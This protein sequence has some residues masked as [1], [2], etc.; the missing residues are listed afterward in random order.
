MVSRWKVWGA[1]VALWVWGASAVGAQAAATTVSIQVPPAQRLEGATTVA[2]RAGEL[3]RNVVV[4]KSNLP[5]TLVAHVVE[6]SGEV[7]W[8][9][10]G[11][12]WQPIG[13]RSPV[14]S[15]RPGVHAVDYQLRVVAGPAGG[16]LA[17]VR[18]SV[19]PALP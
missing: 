6:G 19:I 5:W 3:V 15:G 12:T 2:A 16:P 1:A 14:L 18:F 7:L 8:R 10:A 4:V 9:V 17:L 11:G 13:S